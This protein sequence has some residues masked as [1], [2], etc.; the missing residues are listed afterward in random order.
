[1][2]RSASVIG[3]YGVLVV[4][5]TGIYWG[6][7]DQTDVGGGNFTSANGIETLLGG[8]LGSTFSN[9]AR[10]AIKRQHYSWSGGPAAMPT[11]FETAN[12]AAT[13]PKVIHY[14]AQRGDGN[15]PVKYASGH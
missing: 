6:A 1:M 14:I 11:S 8:V 2:A 7:E 4:P 5:Y 12:D 13:S 10:M 3:T 15:F 9:P